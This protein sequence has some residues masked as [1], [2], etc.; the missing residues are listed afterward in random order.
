M[1]KYTLWHGHN[2]ASEYA[3]ATKLC[4]FNLDRAR[5]CTEQAEL[6]KNR[7]SFGC[8]LCLFYGDVGV[9]PQARCARS[10][11][12][13]SYCIEKS[14]VSVA[15]D[16]QRDVILRCYGAHICWLAKSRVDQLG[17]VDS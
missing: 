11:P 12:E 10:K 8:Y 17:F 16:G 5:C 13:R 15:C 3:Y 2:D 1:N 7:S 4:C 9:M 6:R 14:W